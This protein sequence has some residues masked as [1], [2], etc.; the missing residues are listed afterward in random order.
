MSLQEAL[1]TVDKLRA[2]GR[3][4][5]AE[6]LCRQILAHHPTQPDALFLLGTIAIS[7]RHPDQ[8]V[9]LI[10]RAIAI[11]GR[12]PEFHANLGAALMM[13]DRKAEG[14]AALEQALALNPNHL[15][16]H[17]NL[18]L[19]RMFEKNLD[20]AK[21]HLKQVVSLDPGNMEASISLAAVLTQSGEFDEAIPLLQAVLQRAPR[22][23]HALLNLGN[24]YFERA[25]YDEAIQT[26]QRLIEVAP[27]S[28]RGHYHLALAYAKAEQIE[29]AVQSYRTAIEL[30]PK[31]FEPHNNLAS[32]LKHLGRREEALEHLRTA[33]RLNPGVPEIQENIASALGAMNRNEE[34]IAAYRAILSNDP[35]VIERCHGGVVVALNQLGRFEESRQTIAALRARLPDSVATIMMKANDGATRLEPEEITRAKAYVDQRPDDSGDFVS[36]NLCFVLGKEFA[37][38]GAHDQAFH[39]FARGNQARDREHLYAQD[40]DREKLR[41]DIEAYTPALFERLAGFGDPSTRP[42]FIVGMPRSGTTLTEQILASHPDVAGAG[43]LRAL[44]KVALGMR[45]A[46]GDLLPYP[47]CMGELTREVAR[48]MTDQ[49]LS[50]LAEVD[51]NTARVTD[52]MPD[53]FAHLGLIAALFPRARIIHCRR[54]PRDTCLS[55]YCQNFVD[56]HPYFYDLG[57]LA[58]YYRLYRGWM[59]HWRRVLPIP[60]LE[61]DYEETVADQEGVSR[62][63]LAYCGL[64]WD[65]GVLAFH[66]TERAV[67]TASV[68]QVRQPIYDRS[69]GRWRSYERHLGP[70]LEGLRDLSD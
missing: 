31:A 48:S 15:R 10:R 54:D 16:A 27:Q 52:K 50:A 24:A 60:M 4:Q 36:T 49:Y 12:N 11:N 67:K 1:A 13:L 45:E 69:V 63:L 47:Q 19:A 38:A 25:S 55:I 26:Y 66:E 34:A 59:A 9:D 56:F 30:N 21:H 70:L 6:G 46:L 41:A 44:G 51:P 14:I 3:L 2:T 22:H 58:Q 62:R 68:W 65:E 32:L 35:G 7:A 53:N 28:S 5:E 57:K 20:A 40:K 8:G 23:E 37:R 64:D 61:I 29:Q 39:Y 42:V 17:Y 18:G 43:E 33:D